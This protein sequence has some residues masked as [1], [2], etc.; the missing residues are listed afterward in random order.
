MPTGPANPT[1]RR[2]NFNKPVLGVLHTLGAVSNLGLYAWLMK[3]IYI[4][5]SDGP[6]QLRLQATELI[7][8]GAADDPD[9][10]WN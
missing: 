7:Y 6:R 9:S 5:I 4:Y 2:A 3:Y 10:I 8:Q 1:V